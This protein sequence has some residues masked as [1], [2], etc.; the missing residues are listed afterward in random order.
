LV[1]GLVR[2]LKANVCY[3]WGGFGNFTAA[4]GEA[5][6]DVEWQSYSRRT[7]SVEL[8]LTTQGTAKSGEQPEGD[9]TAIVQAFGAASRNLLAR[10]EFHTLIAGETRPPPPG[11]RSYTVAPP[12]RR[13]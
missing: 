7:R 1:A 4:K 2:D 9:V 5:W 6:V 10:S 11:E 8:K 3:P 12:R 13:S